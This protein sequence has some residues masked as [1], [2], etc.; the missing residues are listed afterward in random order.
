MGAAQEEEAHMEVVCPNEAVEKGAKMRKDGGRH[1]NKVKVQW[2]E[3]LHRERLDRGLQWN[4]FCQRQR[5]D[6]RRILKLS[7]IP[8]DGVS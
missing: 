5:L 6:R 8:F 2:N 7:E 3:F 4:Q 1:Q